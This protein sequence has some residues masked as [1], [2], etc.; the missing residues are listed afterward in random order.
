MF[1]AKSTI[2]EKKIVDFGYSAI[3]KKISKIVLTFFDI[4]GILSEVAEHGN[5]K[6]N[7]ITSFKSL[8]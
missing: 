7:E 8:L 3:C 2:F 1:C 4:R 5:N 6:N